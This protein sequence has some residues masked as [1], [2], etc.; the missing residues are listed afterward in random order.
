VPIITG[1]VVHQQAP[2]NYLHP[3]HALRRYLDS[4]SD[5]TVTEA[6]FGANQ[7]RVVTVDS[8]TPGNPPEDAS[9]QI[10]QPDNTPDT[11]FVQPA[12]GAG[13]KFFSGIVSD[14]HDHDD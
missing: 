3:V 12:F 8:S 7:G 5:N 4:L 13:P 11:T 1:P 2:D 6:Q 9:L 14:G 10:N